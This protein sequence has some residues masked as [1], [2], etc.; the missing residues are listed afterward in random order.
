MSDLGE[1]RSRIP[2]NFRCGYAVKMRCPVPFTVLNVS[3]LAKG[4]RKV[5]P[6]RGLAIN[7]ESVL[8]HPVSS[9]RSMS[10]VMFFFLSL[11]QWMFPGWSG[12]HSRA[13]FV[14]P[15]DLVLFQFSG[16]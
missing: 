1:I 14:S 7:Y 6:F 5:V 2:S 10:L 4:R 12:I 15:L 13:T 9:Y 3:L 8:V 11:K 16:V